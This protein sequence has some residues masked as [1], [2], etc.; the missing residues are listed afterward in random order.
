MFFAIEI[1]VELDNN[2]YKNLK[3]K[4]TNYINNQGYECK[5]FDSLQAAYIQQEVEYRNDNYKYFDFVRRL[6]NNEISELVDTIYNYDDNFSDLM[7]NID[8]EF[9]KFQVTNNTIN[10][11]IS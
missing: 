9:R 10:D 3:N 11:K 8:D 2:E 6:N 1:D 7:D 4:I 5:I